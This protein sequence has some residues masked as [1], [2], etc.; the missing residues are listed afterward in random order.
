MAGLS[1]DAPLAELSEAEDVCVIICPISMLGWPATQPIDAI[2]TVTGTHEGS[3]T[4]SSWHQLPASGP[5]LGP[6]TC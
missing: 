3:G 4:S 1:L 5:L 2:L 6:A